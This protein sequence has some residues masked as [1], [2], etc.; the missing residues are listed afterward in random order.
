MMASL[1]IGEFSTGGWS[2]YP[3]YT[4]LAFSPGVGPDYW[5]WAV[6][7]GS[8]GSTLT[9]I[10]FA[11]T[12]YKMRCPGMHLMRMP[13]FVWTA[14]CTSHPDDLRDAAADRRDGAARARPLSGVPFLHERPRRQH[15]E[16]CQP[17]L[18]VRPSR[19]LYPDPACL[20]RLFGGGFDLFHQGALRLH[21]ARSRNGGD[22]AAVV[23]RVGSPLLHHGPERRYQRRVR[24]RDDDDRRAD[25]RQDLRLDLD[26]VS[27]RGAFYR[28]DALLARIHDDIRAGR[29]YR[30]PPR[31]SSAGLSWCTI[32]CS[33]WRTFTTC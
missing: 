15:D 10:N 2:G 8:I 7:L 23:H 11:V 19:G 9:G 30:N 33:W 5:I 4:E 6:T 16:L 29:V 25:G 26:H 21:L 13:L 1:V 12:I 32:P 31:L 20:W 3:P 17:V 24:H 22:R 18:A 28:A 14:L 27:R